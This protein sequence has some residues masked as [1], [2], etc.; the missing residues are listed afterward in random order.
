MKQKMVIRVHMTC[1]KCRSKAMGLVASVHGVERVEI[2][3]DD[4]DCLAVVGDGV[5]AANLT[6]CLRKKVGSAELLTVEAVG[7]EKKPAAA[8]ETGEASCP[9]QWYPG[10]YSWPGGAYSYCYPYSM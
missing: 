8:S 1:D 7:S 4:R 2:Q 9:Q 5:D 6:A 10:Y 3:G